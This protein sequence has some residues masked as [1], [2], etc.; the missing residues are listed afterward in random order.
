MIQ[1][2][3]HPIHENR[4]QY[5]VPPPQGLSE[6]RRGKEV[7]FLIFLFFLVINPPSGAAAVIVPVG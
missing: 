3:S 6:A 2:S 4:S 1:F 7:Y 5:E